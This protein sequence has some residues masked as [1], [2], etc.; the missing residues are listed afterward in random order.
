MQFSALPPARHSPASRWAAIWVSGLC[1]WLPL[2]LRNTYMDLIHAK[3]A[4]LTAFVLLGLL[5]LAISALTDLRAFRPLPGR[6]SPGMLWLPAWC[7]SYLLAWLFSED[8]FASLWGLTGRRNG[9]ALFA[10]CTACYLLTRLFCPAG[11]YQGLCRLF[12]GCSCLIALLG[13]LNAWGPDPLGTYYSLLPDNGSLYLSTIGNLNFFAAYLCLCLPLAVQTAFH[14]RSGHSRAGVVLC[15]VVLLTGLLMASTDAAWL[16]L[17]VMLAVVFC[18]RRLTWHGARLLFA[19]GAI[20]C[21]VAFLTG[22][23]LNFFPLRMPLRTVSAVLVKPFVCLPIGALLLFLFFISPRLKKTPCKPARLLF[24]GLLLLLLCG[25]LVR[26]LFGLSLGPLDSFFWLRSGWGSNRWDV[27]DVLVR[28]YAKL[29]LLQ[30]LVGV[31]A[32]GV[33]ALLNPYYTQALI[34]LNGDTFDS[35][36]NEYLQHML[37]GG[38][39]GLVCWCGFLFTHI[40]SAFRRVPFLATALIGYAVQAFFSITTP[41]LIVPVCLLAAFSAAP[42]EQQPIT[43]DRWYF[44]LGSTLLFPALVVMWMPF[45]KTIHSPFWV[46][47]WMVFVC[48]SLDSRL[49]ACYNKTNT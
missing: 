9:L 32:D 39:L 15:C 46:P 22:I 6:V 17:A 24:G 26:N 12:T 23:F 35:A 34:A 16:S 8:R 33:D 21:A 36:H 37:C 27:W 29:P 49:T 43:L 5:G 4:L 48:Y 2:Y 7:A 41:M 28:R 11:L 44:F 45:Y 31:G 30:K 13:I 40:R 38:L 42:A 1:L 3:F 19:I 25:F 20:F 18:D 47:E 14:A 10:C